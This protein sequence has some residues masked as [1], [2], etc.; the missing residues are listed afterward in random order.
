MTT[1]NGNVYQGQ[2]KNDTKEGMGVFY[3]ADR[4]SRYEGLWRNDVAQAGSY[5]RTVDP[6]KLPFVMVPNSQHLER[7]CIRLAS[8]RSLPPHYDWT[9]KRSDPAVCTRKY[10]QVS[11][12]SPLIA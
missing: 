5:T 9:T 12:A 6:E 10:A 7:E 2:F 4:Q 11:Y 1:V 8:T 3:F